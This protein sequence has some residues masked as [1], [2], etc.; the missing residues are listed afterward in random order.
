MQTSRKT[1]FTYLWLA[2]LVFQLGFTVRGF[3]LIFILRDFGMPAPFLSAITNFLLTCLLL[4]ILHHNNAFLG[5]V[6]QETKLKQYLTSLAATTGALIL[7]FIFA[8]TYQDLLHK[9]WF[10]ELWFYI[11][12]TLSIL[13][14]PIVIPF[15]GRAY[16]KGIGKYALILIS[17]EA[18]AIIRKL[19]NKDLSDR[20]VRKSIMTQNMRFWFYFD[21]LILTFKRPLEEIYEIFLE[22]AGQFFDIQEKSR[23]AFNRLE[24]LDAWRIFLDTLV[25]KISTPL[26]LRPNLE[27]SLEK[28]SIFLRFSNWTIRFLESNPLFS[29]QIEYSFPFLRSLWNASFMPLKNVPLGKLGTKSPKLRELLRNHI[30]RASSYDLVV[31]G[32]KVLVFFLLLMAF[33]LTM[34]LDFVINLPRLIESNGF[35]SELFRTYGILAILYFSTN[36][37]L[38]LLQ[39]SMRS[40]GVNYI[41]PPRF[42]AVRRYFYVSLIYLGFFLPIPPIMTIVQNV[43]A[44]NL[45]PFF[46]VINTLF[47]YLFVK[48]FQTP[49]K[50]IVTYS[51]SLLVRELM[52]LL[53]YV[54][55]SKAV[56]YKIRAIRSL[57]YC[58]K[59][60]LLFGIRLQALSAVQSQAD[61]VKIFIKSINKYFEQTAYAIN[62]GSDQ[63]RLKAMQDIV[64]IA[65]SVITGDLFII[66]E[67]I[68]DIDEFVKVG[69]GIPRKNIFSLLIH[70]IDTSWIARVILS[71]LFLLL[72]NQLRDPFVWQFLDKLSTILQF[73][74]R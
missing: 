20:L 34:W 43:V 8:F 26:Y 58:K 63:V 31:G 66:Q 3:P 17:I 62:L 54:R 73:F 33:S 18:H 14:I 71:V 56:E 30:E 40:N 46:L 13:A 6:T 45:T 15:F 70:L 27:A 5:E 2:F 55:S 11:P 65:K 25:R 74:S 12:L 28:D 35:R 36:S 37:G 50:L 4:V 9:D 16:A 32:N 1:V 44:S 21:I 68:P 38:R 49:R 7:F 69:L 41:V 53:I 51:D 42:Y 60:F 67:Q 19:K 57:T 23:K 59:L 10:L 64:V 24:L 61:N 22:P 72:I 29:T 52:R 47:F 39:R 48:A